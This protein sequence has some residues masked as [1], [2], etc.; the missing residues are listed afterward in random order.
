MLSGS[1]IETSVYQMSSKTMTIEQKI[2]RRALIIWFKK[3]Q[4]NFKILNSKRLK[5][6]GLYD[7]LWLQV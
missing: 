2:F 6:I 4:W 1:K 7:W 3:I 5:R